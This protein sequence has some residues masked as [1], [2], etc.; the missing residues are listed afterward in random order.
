MCLSLH[1]AAA[2]KQQHHQSVTVAVRS[3]ILECDECLVE[4]QNFPDAGEIE[5][6]G[7]GRRRGVRFARDF[8][9]ATNFQGGFVGKHVCVSVW[10]CVVYKCVCQRERERER[11]FMDA[12][13]VCVCVCVCVHARAIVSLGE[14]ANVM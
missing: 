7:N 3:S 11:L 14:N 12:S 6:S 9:T 10:E 8:S 13:S 4:A 1:R 2:T 5:F